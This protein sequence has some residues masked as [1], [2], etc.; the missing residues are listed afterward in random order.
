MAF[1][2]PEESRRAEKPE[3]R[4]YDTAESR[5]QGENVQQKQGRSNL[6]RRKQGSYPA[7]ANHPPRCV[8]NVRP[9]E[10]ICVPIVARL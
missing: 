9:S 10:A 7:T 5:E 4:I 6:D 1:T 2:L 3:T 8:K